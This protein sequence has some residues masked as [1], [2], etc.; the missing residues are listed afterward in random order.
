MS[1]VKTP[2]VAEPKQ[3]EIKDARALFQVTWGD[4]HS[5][6][7]PFWYLRGYCPC[8]ECQGHGGGWAFVEPGEAK[9]KDVLEVGHYALNL[10]WSDGHRTGIY[11]FEVLRTLC[12]CAVCRKTTGLNHPWDRLPE[13]R[14]RT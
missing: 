5:S 2:A 12:P 6:Q 13:A 14:Q 3:I 9:L 7:Y 1:Q 11:P 4:D 10:T 8:A